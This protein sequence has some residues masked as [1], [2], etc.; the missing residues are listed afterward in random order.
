MATGTG[1][2]LTKALRNAFQGKIDVETDVIKVA[3]CSAVGTQSAMEFFNDATEISGDGYTA[4]GITLAAKSI[5]ASTLDV[6]FDDTGS[7][8]WTA[9]ASGIAAAFGVVYVVG[10]AGTT[11]YAISTIDFGGIQT[12][13]SGNTF[14][15][16]WDNVDGV[17]KGTVIAG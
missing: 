6:I 10:S 1:E 4:G 2:V 8:E 13:T 5:T 3:L 9:G 7:P 12:A 14:T 11:D 16:A 17:F 15:I